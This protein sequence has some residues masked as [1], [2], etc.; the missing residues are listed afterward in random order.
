MTT[1]S[2]GTKRC[3]C[4]RECMSMSAKKVWNEADLVIY[5]SQLMWFWQSQWMP[6]TRSTPARGCSTL[7][8]F[9]TRFLLLLPLQYLPRRITYQHA[10]GCAWNP[11]PHTLAGGNL[12]EWEIWNPTHSVLR[13]RQA[14]I[15]GAS[16]DILLA[17]LTSLGL[18]WSKYARQVSTFFFN[19][20]HRKVSTQFMWNY[21][22]LI[23]KFQCEFILVPNR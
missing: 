9:S 3:S 22:F 5:K 13:K 7:S 19:C 11:L 20:I 8:S 14:A 23:L 1:I 17:S 16:F 2:W 21:T 12:R 10:N 18:V 15:C 6:A 4:L